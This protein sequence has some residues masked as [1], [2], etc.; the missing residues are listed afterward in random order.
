M[1][2]VYF[3]FAQKERYI[4]LRYILKSAKNR[5]E[6]ADL[7]N[8]KTVLKRHAVCMRDTLSQIGCA[9]KMA[10]WTNVEDVRFTMNLHYSVDPG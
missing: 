8:F 9:R 2:R 1:T 5:M 7:T 10:Q 3:K 4:K 6:E